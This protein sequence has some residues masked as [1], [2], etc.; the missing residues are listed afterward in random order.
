MSSKDT[1]NTP[2]DAPA[3]KRR[4][5]MTWWAPVL[6]AVMLLTYPTIFANATWVTTDMVMRAGELE[7]TME[8]LPFTYRSWVGQEVP[9]PPAAR[10]LLSTNAIFSRAYKKVSGPDMVNIVAVFCSD[11]RDI[12]GHYPPV[13]YPNAGW[14]ADEENGSEKNDI[15]LVYGD[16]IIP[17][18]I[19]EFTQFDDEGKEIGIRVIDFFILPDGTISRE[20]AAVRKQSSRLDLSMQGTAQFQLITDRN[21]SEVESMELCE[22]IL[23]VLDELF[24]ALDA[25]KGSKEDE[26]DD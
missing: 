8:N 23:P 22:D 5:P 16:M 15:E 7:E 10:R 6:S 19:Y 14:T 24:E 18:S 26:A 1:P 4:L 11:A 20:M 13:C 2:V 21:L 25:G 17:A 12:I 3:S 9:V